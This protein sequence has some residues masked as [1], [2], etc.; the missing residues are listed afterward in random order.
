MDKPISF[1]I[2]N[3]KNNN[4]LLKKNQIKYLLQKYREIKYPS[5][6]KY[7]ADISKIKITFE[8]TNTNMINLPLCYKSA[9]FINLKNKNKLDKYVIIT[10]NFQINM[11]KKCTHILIDGTFKSCP[12][13][14]SQIIN[15]AGYYPD[16]NSIIPIFMIPASGKSEYLYDM[17]FKDVI[18]IINDEGYKIDNITSNFI[19]DFEKGLQNSVRKNFKKAKI[20]GCYFHFVKLLWG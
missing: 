10:S 1:H 13:G 4:V 11:L 3:N 7:L 9:S 17:I 5:N 12:K 14:Y 19:T 20:D 18:Q 2:E 16:I 15:I 8:E 6:N